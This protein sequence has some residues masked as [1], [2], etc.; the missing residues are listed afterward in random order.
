MEIKYKEYQA[1]LENKYIQ[2]YQEEMKISIEG[3]KKNILNKK[4]DLI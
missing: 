4:T 2:K 1:Q 3:I